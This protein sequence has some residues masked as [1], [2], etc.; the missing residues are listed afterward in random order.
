M[1]YLCSLGSNI[2][3]L[4]HVPLC[5][6]QLCERIPVI[7]FS[8]FIQTEPMGMAT[9]NHFVNGLAWF[10]SQQSPAQLKRFFNQLEARHGRNRHDPLSSA[11]DRCLDIDVVHFAGS[12]EELSLAPIEP[13]LSRLHQQLFDT[14][15]PVIED[16]LKLEIQLTAQHCLPLGQRAT[17]IHFNR[18]T[19]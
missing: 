19:R 12:F 4:Q 16:A 18:A 17:T 9:N 5:V 1:L 8:S 6:R 15:S 13:F 11:K 14:H 10:E 7:T 3:P 2:E